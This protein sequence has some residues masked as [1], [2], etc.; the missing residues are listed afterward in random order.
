M[1]KITIVLLAFILILTGCQSSENKAITISGSTSVEEFMTNVV[2]PAYNAD[3]GN[4]IEYQSVGSTAGI[5]NAMSGTT[6]FGTSSRDLKADEQESGLS[7]E[8][9]AIDG[10]AIIVNPNNS[11]NDITKDDLIKIYRGEITNWNQIGGNNQEIQVVS[12]E[13][14]SG[15]RGAFEELLD[16][17][18]KIT[19]DATIANGNGNVANTVAQNEAAIGYISFET[20][21]A[22]KD[23]VQGLKLDGVEPSASEVQK[24]NYNLSRPFVMVYDEN[25]LTENDKLFIEFIQNNKK[26]LAPEA[27]LIEASN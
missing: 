7:Q 18:G 1:K 3:T 10:I 13:E 6:T 21:Y 15:T 12:R 26:S 8:I 22:N 11:L 2:A 9:I 27:G 14:G 16:I 19:T 20:L 25:K 24:G 23:K 5:K 17:E 4:T